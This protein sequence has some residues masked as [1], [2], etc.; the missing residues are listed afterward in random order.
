MD[1]IV[2]TQTRP[3]QILQRTVG[4]GFGKKQIHPIAWAAAGNG[5]GHCL[6][7]LAA[8]RRVEGGEKWIT[9]VHWICF[10]VARTKEIITNQMDQNEWWAK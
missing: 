10:L 3:C 7:C 8:A 5:V 4:G 1:R 2:Q 9:A 6:I